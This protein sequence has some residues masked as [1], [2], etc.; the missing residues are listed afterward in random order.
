VC[1]SVSLC[2]NKIPDDKAE[3]IKTAVARIETQRVINLEEYLHKNKIPQKSTKSSK[4]AGASAKS[5][6]KGTGQAEVKTEGEAAGGEAAP[7][8]N[9]QDSNAPGSAAIV[10]D[11]S[12]SSLPPAAT[13]G[14]SSVGSLD[15]GRI[16]SAP[17]DELL[18]LSVP[19]VVVV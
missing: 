3:E 4:R 6:N 14:E 8:I 10:A 18:I 9:D 1:A 2:R 19:K 7:E 13:G 5:S 15:K 17:V 16:L 11:G 12:D